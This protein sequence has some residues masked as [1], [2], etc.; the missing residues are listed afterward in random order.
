[1]FVVTQSK[2]YE[3]PCIMSR[4]LFGIPPNGIYILYS[5]KTSQ[6]VAT[7]CTISIFFSIHY[8]QAFGSGNNDNG[9]VSNQ[10]CTAVA[11]TYICLSRCTEQH[12]LAPLPKALG[13]G[14][15]GKTL[16]TEKVFPRNTYSQNYLIVFTGNIKYSTSSLLLTV[17]TQ[18]MCLANSILMVSPLMTRRQSA[19]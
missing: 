3:M 12:L 5:P 11:Q 8:F 7:H 6:V 10:Y 19:R 15:R 4:K 9:K 16:F 18:P 17:I 14:A 13:K 1:M 2:C